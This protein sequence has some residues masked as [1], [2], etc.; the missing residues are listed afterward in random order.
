MPQGSVYREE[1][2]A[3]W[4]FMAMDDDDDDGLMASAARPAC[5]GSLLWRG[6][7]GILRSGLQS[8]LQWTPPLTRWLIFLP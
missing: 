4:A 7:N 2:G 8:G 1:P 6:S 5:R 3:F